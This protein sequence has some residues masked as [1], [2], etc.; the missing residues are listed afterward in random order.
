MKYRLLFLL[1]LGQYSIAQ[2]SISIAPL[3]IGKVYT[4]S[5]GSDFRFS[6]LYS[7]QLNTD[8][9]N[10]YM[11]FRAKRMS[12]RPSIDLGL[13]VELAF[14]DNKHRLG[15][16]WAQDGTGTMSKSTHFTTVNSVG[17]PDSLIPDYKTYGNYTSYFHTGFV[18]NR[19]SLRYQWRLTQEDAVFVTYIMPELAVI[20][21][22]EN[23][24]SWLYE[25]DTLVSNATLFHNDAKIVSTEIN[26]YYN[27]GTSVLLGVGLKTDIFTKKQHKYLFSVDLSFKQGFKEIAGSTEAVVI[28]DSGKKFAIINE[29]VATGS[30]FYLQISRSFRL[31]TW[32][33][34]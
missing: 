13:Q 8:V 9:Q 27:G 14:N 31:K 12:I 19:I 1:M 22:Q 24:Q 16:E 32:A 6:Q 33:K 18:F 26:A 29:L 7:E 21:G 2:T 5:Y 23:R 20:I 34:K 17:V 3:V 28:E 11:T 10:P 30:G 15:L 4:C 25:N